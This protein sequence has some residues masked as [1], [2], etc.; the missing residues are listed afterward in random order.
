[1]RETGKHAGG[2]RETTIQFHVALRAILVT[3]AAR[4]CEPYVRAWLRSPDGINILD[5]A[6]E[7]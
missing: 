3:R 6:N 4:T 1:M 5:K 2:G 7:S